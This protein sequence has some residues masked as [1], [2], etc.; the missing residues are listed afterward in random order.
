MVPI[1]NNDPQRSRIAMLRQENSIKSELRC[2][3]G[4]LRLQIKLFGGLVV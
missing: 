3:D 2:F 4:I 1:N